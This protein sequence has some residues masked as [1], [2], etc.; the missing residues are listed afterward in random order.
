MRSEV[1]SLLSAIPHMSLDELLELMG[2]LETV[3]ETAKFKMVHR[4]HPDPALALDRR[5]GVKEAAKRLGVS[6]GYVYHHADR[7]PFTC[8]EGGRLLFSDRGI[9]DYLARKKRA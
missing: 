3:R 4:V 6:T 1:E 5:I 8:R 9:D 2:Q 7:F